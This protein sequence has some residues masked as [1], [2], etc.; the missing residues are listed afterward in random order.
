MPEGLFNIKSD[1]FLWGKNAH[2]LFILAGIGT[3][4]YLQLKK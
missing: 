2:S 1:N 3:I 4:I